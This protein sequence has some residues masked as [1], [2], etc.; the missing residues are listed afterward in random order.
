MIIVNKN[1]GPK[2]EYTVEDTVIAFGEG[3]DTLALNLA[4]IQDEWNIHLLICFDKAGNLILGP[5]L[6]YVAEIDIP[7]ITWHEEG[8]GEEAHSEPDPLDMDKVMLT[9]WAV[10]KKTKETVEEE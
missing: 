5:G 9:L 7:A 6:T 1:Y 8:E 3:E 2:I 4:E 10:D